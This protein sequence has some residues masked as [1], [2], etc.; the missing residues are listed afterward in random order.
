MLKIV[1][2]IPGME[3][4]KRYSIQEEVLSFWANENAK[5]AE[6]DT[7]GYKNID[8]AGA[9]YRDAIN[10]LFLRIRTITR[11]GKLYLV[12]GKDSDEQK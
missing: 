4:K 3:R 7:T 11:D 8:S 5:Y 10:S 1:K 9:T 6:V 2:S 12:K